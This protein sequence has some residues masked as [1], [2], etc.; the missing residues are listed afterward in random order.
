MGALC[1]VMMQ[2][3]GQHLDTGLHTLQNCEVHI[4]S[5]SKLNNNRRKEEEK[6]MEKRERRK[7]PITAINNNMRRTSCSSATLLHARHWAG[8]W[9]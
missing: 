5:L 7:R 1:R 3:A 6:E 9:S 4:F 2:E 8:C